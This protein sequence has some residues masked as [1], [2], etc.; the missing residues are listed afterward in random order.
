MES[1]KRYRI[2][3]LANLLATQEI[4]SQELRRRQQRIVAIDE[5]LRVQDLPLRAVTRTTLLIDVKRHIPATATFD[6]TITVQNLLYQLPVTYW[7]DFSKSYP[8]FYLEIKDAL[9]QKKIDLNQF[10]E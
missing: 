6:Q 8:K 5:H 10:A 9:R 1:L 3:S 7:S 4:I 2:S